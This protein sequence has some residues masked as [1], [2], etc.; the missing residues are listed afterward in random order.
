MTITKSD[1]ATENKSFL[2]L[3][4]KKFQDHFRSNDVRRSVQRNVKT[5]RMQIRATNSCY[6]SNRIIRDFSQT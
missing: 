3:F 2:H 1:K 6:T 4:E 5:I